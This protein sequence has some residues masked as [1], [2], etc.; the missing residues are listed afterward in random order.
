MFGR[1]NTARNK[2]NRPLR[3]V[4]YNCAGA[5]HGLH[6]VELLRSLEADIV[7]LQE[8]E[9]YPAYSNYFKSINNPNLAE[10]MAVE[11]GL[12]ADYVPIHESHLLSKYPGEYIKLPL[13]RYPQDQLH[14]TTFTNMPVV[15]GETITLESPPLSIAI[16][17]EIYEGHSKGIRL[18]QSEVDGRAVTIANL[19]LPSLGF[20]KRDPHEDT[21]RNFYRNVDETLGELEGEVIVCGDFNLTPKQFRI[22]LPRTYAKYKG[23][24]SAPRLTSYGFEDRS[25]S[26]VDGEAFTGTPA[27]KDY[28]LSTLQHHG[29]GAIEFAGSDHAP[30]VEEF[31]LGERSGSV[32]YPRA[33]Q[34]APTA[35]ATSEE[36]PALTEL[37]ILLRE[38]SRITTLHLFEL[39]LLYLNYQVK[40]GTRIVVDP[41]GRR[42]TASHIERILDKVRERVADHP[43]SSGEDIL[44]EPYVGWL[45]GFGLNNF[46]QLLKEF[47]TTKATNYPD[48]SPIATEVFHEITAVSDIYFVPI[49]GATATSSTDL[50]DPHE[51]AISG[52]YHYRLNLLSEPGYHEI[53]S[54]KASGLLLL[55]IHP[56]HFPELNKSDEMLQ[57]VEYRPPAAGQTKPWSL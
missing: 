6:I 11:L 8:V 1:L 29:G 16:D 13:K 22:L 26:H 10:T 4:S 14:L 48:Y 24:V 44:E 56:L 57:L 30:L 49:I 32:S 50:S 17:G 36:S 15:G 39:S 37:R 20:F 7:C 46:Y 18:T 52:L 19:H 42:I 38:K 5:R 3:V 51:Q 47:A 9:L 34:P 54:L 27:R 25:V 12:N 41:K 35:R 31:E 21:F 2:G 33:Q 45:I 23:L 55:F 40:S 28:V 53:S 43:Q